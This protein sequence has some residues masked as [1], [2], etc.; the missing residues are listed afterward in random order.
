VFLFQA[1]P[2]AKASEVSNVQVLNDQYK[3]LYA[4]DLAYVDNVYKSKG[5]KIKDIVGVNN[6]IKDAIGEWTVIEVSK[7]GGSVL[8]GFEAIVLKNPDKT[9]NELII[10]YKG[11]A[12]TL[13]DKDWVDNFEALKNI[14][15]EITQKNGLVYHPQDVNAD[16]FTQAI[17]NQYDGANFIFTGHSLGGHLAQRAK[18]D[19][20]R[21]DI[22]VITF[23]SLGVVT[24]EKIADF[25]N[26]LKGNSNF[27]IAGE[28][29]DNTNKQY[30]ISNLGN[31]YTL[32]L[33]N[34]T[35]EVDKHRLV[36]FYKFA[37]KKT[38]SVY[39]NN[40]LIKSFYN[41][42]N[43]KQLASMNIK[44][45]VKDNNQKGK[46]IWESKFA[47]YFHQKFLYSFPDR[48]SSDAYANVQAGRR[49]LD[50]KT[51][52][53]V[54]FK[55]S[56]AFRFSVYLG[57]DKLDIFTTSGEAIKFAKLNKNRIVKDEKT[58]KVI[59]PIKK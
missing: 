20:K 58:K 41:V 28:L 8:T 53:N 2:I 6:E 43:A 11:S 32:E 10:S 4:S 29:V 17:I 39:Q 35:S 42:N 19:L 25:A 59:Y 37:N 7:D 44:T 50:L 27:V 54:Y 45:I 49:V 34:V 46:V 56:T 38:Y 33:P 51:N 5:K 48:K 23:N 1:I 36:N 26:Y 55:T 24:E 3:E 22:K 47:V 12:G 14:N 16:L 18:I 40:K 21:E 15:S 31:K 30:F 13:S 9:K 57:K 52:K